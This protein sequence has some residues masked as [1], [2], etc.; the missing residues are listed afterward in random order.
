MSMFKSYDNLDT[1]YVPNNVAEK[2]TNTFIRMDKSLP[3]KI[4][5][6]KNRF[7]G[8]TWNQ[9]DIL[10]FNIS[11]ADTIK[12]KK[13]SLVY[14]YSGQGPDTKTP[15]YRYQ[16]AYNLIDCVSWTC[17]DIVN[18]VY[19]WLRDECLTYSAD[20][21]KEITFTPDMLSKTLKVD[22]YNFRWELIKSYEKHYS[23]DITIE[24]DEELSQELSSGIYHCVVSVAT[25]IETYTR[26]TFMIYVK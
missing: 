3:K 20:G 19:V 16:Q 15:G 21:T 18:G 2:P 23:N 4:Y 11:V 24:V 6:I 1:N 13:D 22:L 17:V 12:V 8:Y 14:E 5:N 25:D 10:Q 9:G 26:N 7:I